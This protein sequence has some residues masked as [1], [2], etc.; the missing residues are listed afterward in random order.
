MSRD[1]HVPAW[2]QLTQGSSLN[3]SKSDLNNWKHSTLLKLD[4]VGCSTPS[5]RA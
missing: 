3:R 5:T 4:R 2:F 1:Q